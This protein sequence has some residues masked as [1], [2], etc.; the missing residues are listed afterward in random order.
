MWSWELIAKFQILTNSRLK[1]R[2]VVFLGFIQDPFL[3]TQ[4]KKLVQ[5]KTQ[6]PYPNQN[7]KHNEW[8][9]KICFI[10]QQS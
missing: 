6:F 4:K 5:T 7:L 1:E 9:I 3:H 10:N 2:R 8:P